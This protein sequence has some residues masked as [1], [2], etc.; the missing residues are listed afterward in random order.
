MELGWHS[1]VHRVALP[2]LVLARLSF[3]SADFVLKRARFSLLCSS[4]F[5][6]YQM[7]NSDLKRNSQLKSYI[8]KFHFFLQVLKLNRNNIFLFS[9][10]HYICHPCIHFFHFLSCLIAARKDTLNCLW[11]GDVVASV[12]I[13][14]PVESGLGNEYSGLRSSC[15]CVPVRSQFSYFSVHLNAII[16]YT[17]AIMFNFEREARTKSAVFVPTLPTKLRCLC[18]RVGKHSPHTIR[19]RSCLP[20]S[21]RPQFIPIFYSIFFLQPKQW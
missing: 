6:F 15:C 20:L 13:P 11:L 3:L 17:N 16:K 1:A 4:V 12:C 18:L 2:V 9:Q 10:S 8:H 5:N 7:E 21:S 14:F 19:T